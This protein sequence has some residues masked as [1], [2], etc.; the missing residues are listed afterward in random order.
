MHEAR[1]KLNLGKCVFGVTRSKVLRCLVSTK[2]IEANPDKIK[3]ILKMQHPQTKKEVQKL[4]GHIASLNRFIEKQV[5]Q[6]CPFF[7]VLRGSA[8]L[9]CGPEQ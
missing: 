7:S 6:S 2:G 3:A 4:T 5:E 8:R 1:H 9:E